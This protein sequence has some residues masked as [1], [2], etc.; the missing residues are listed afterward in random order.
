MRGVFCGERCGVSALFVQRDSNNHIQTF[1][2]SSLDRFLNEPCA[3]WSRKAGKQAE[4]WVGPGPGVG[5][6]SAF[7]WVPEAPS[8]GKAV[9]QSS[10]PKGGGTD[11]PAQVGLTAHTSTP[12]LVH[13][14]LPRT[15]K[16]TMDVLAFERT[17]V[18]NNSWRTCWDSVN[19]PQEGEPMSSSRYTKG[20]KILLIAIDD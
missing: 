1:C 11:L 10:P 8:W 17:R 15:N 20:P 3:K 7:W 2:L 5:K 9:D 18:T 4:P 19:I 6:C 14:P 13:L 12:C 16:R